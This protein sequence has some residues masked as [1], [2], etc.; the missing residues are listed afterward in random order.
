MWLS[1]GVANAM[2]MRQNAS[3]ASLVEERKDSNANANIIRTGKIV[4]SVCRC[5]MA[6][7]GEELQGTPQTLAHVSCSSYLFSLSPLTYCR[8]DHIC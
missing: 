1:A 8:L 7:R 2:V 3:K 6:H 4:K 5:I